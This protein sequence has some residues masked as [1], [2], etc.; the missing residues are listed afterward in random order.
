[1]WTLM[2]KIYFDKIYCE[3]GANLHALKHIE[4]VV[5]PRQMLNILK[6]GDQQ[7]RCDG[8]GAGQQHPRK[9]RP[10]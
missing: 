5:H 10:P 3:G 4:E 6:D 2:L 9:T 7:C 1:M 8:D